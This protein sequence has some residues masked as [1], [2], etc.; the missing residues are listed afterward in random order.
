MESEELLLTW[1]KY[2]IRI[3]DDNKKEKKEKPLIH[4]DQAY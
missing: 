4:Q 1:K 3:F 2:A